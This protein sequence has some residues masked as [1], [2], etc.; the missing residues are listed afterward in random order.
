MNDG[1][2]YLKPYELGRGRVVLHF[3]RENLASRQPSPDAAAIL[4]DPLLCTT[5]T[6]DCLLSELWPNGTVGFY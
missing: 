6:V 1:W 2:C 5:V 3:S 4:T